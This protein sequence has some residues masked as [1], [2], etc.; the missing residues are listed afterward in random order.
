MKGLHLNYSSIGYH[1]VQYITLISMLN[2]LIAVFNI[3]LVIFP[4]DGG[5]LCRALLH[6]LLRRY[7]RLDAR[8]AH[9]LATKIVVRG[10]WITGAVIICVFTYADLLLLPLFILLPLL[11][12]LG[13][14]EL[15]GLRE[16]YGPLENEASREELP[17]VSALGNNML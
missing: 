3:V 11:S 4:A 15:L 17:E 14:I 12:I 6:G 7:S 2:F 13:E 9:L 10:G 5:R 1:I 16:H 8:S